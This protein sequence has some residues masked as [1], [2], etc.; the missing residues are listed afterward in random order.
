MTK[1]QWYSGIQANMACRACRTESDME[2]V[3]TVPHVLSDKPSVGFNRCSACGTLNCDLLVFTDYDE[4]NA[5]MENAQWMRHYLQCGAG[6]DFMIRPLQRISMDGELSL[7]DVGCGVGFT[8]SY[9]NW[10]KRD[11]HGVEPSAYGR[12]GS[13]IVD[14][15][16]IPNYLSD[17]P[18]LNERKFDRVFSSEVIEHVNDPESFVTELKAVTTHDGILILTTPNAGYVDPLNP[19]IVLMAALSPGLHRLIFSQQALEG[20]LR[21]VGFAH[22]CVLEV[23]ERL[24][25][26]ASEVP[27]ERTED[28]T[29]EMNSYLQFLLDKSATADNSDLRGGLLF[30]AFKEQVN[31]GD[32]DSALATRNALDAL[33][34]NDFSLDLTHPE[35]VRKRL[36]RTSTFEEYGS[37]APYFTPAYLFYSA[38]LALQDRAF[39]PDALRGFEIAAELTQHGV[40]LA[41]SLFHEAMMLYWPAKLHVAIAAILLDK[42]DAAKMVLQEILDSDISIIARPDNAVRLRAMRELGVTALQSGEPERAMSLFRQVAERAPEMRADVLALY[43]T[44]C[45][46]AQRPASIFTATRKS[47]LFSVFARSFNRMRNGRRRRA[48]K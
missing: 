25:A 28:P 46:Q 35:Q 39:L 6:I 29:A 48:I 9:W 22:V 36:L 1:V 37:V 27:F 12:L 32:F 4:D 24:I 41:P 14:D 20:L 19:L 43:K 47:S 10:A 17:A 3:I 44:A 34:K 21:R 16:I 26:Y 40:S 42:Q 45:A 8:V 18:A 30:R 31:A 23:N 15:R 7:L 38:M 33:V 13:K 5:P 11:G 2:N